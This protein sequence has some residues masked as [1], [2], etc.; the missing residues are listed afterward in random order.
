MER[1]QGIVEGE[2]DRRAVV[3]VLQEL[4]EAQAGDEFG[5]A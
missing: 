5:Q 4:V 3:D 1:C 2:E